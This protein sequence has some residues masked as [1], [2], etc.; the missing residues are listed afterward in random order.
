MA[1][2]KF[3]CIK[4]SNPSNL[5]IRFYHGRNIDCNAQSH[6]LINP[7]D[8]SEKMQ[9]FKPN[10]DIAI[11][12][13]YNP[14]IDNLKKEIL[15][16][17]N[18][19]YSKGT[20]IN[21]KWLK[22]TIQ[23]FHKR[24]EGIEEYKIYFVSFIEKFIEDSKTR[25]NPVSGKKIADNTLKKYTTTLNKIKEFEKAN[26]IRLK[27]IDI[28][29]EFHDKLTSYLKIDLKYSNTFIA[30]VISQI[31][32]FIREAKEKRLEINPDIESKK[33][34]FTT[35]ETIDTY[36]NPSEIDLIN[37]LDLTDNASLDNV[38]DLFIIGLW[39]GLRISDLKR[40]NHFLFTKN[41]IV[42]SETDK[43][44]VTVEIPIHPQVRNI[45]IKRANKMP[46]VISTQKFNDYI[47]EVCK[48]ARITQIILGNIKDPKTNR[49]VRGHYPK[50]KLIS[51]HTARRSFATNHY[52][53]LPDRTIMACTGHKSLQ[54]FHKYLKA[55]QKDH[56]EK[57]ETYW[58]QQDELKNAKPTLKSVNF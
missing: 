38:R 27:L 7:S 14:L 56:I 50:Y 36:L 18:I 35:D 12:N 54:Q 57:I 21:S 20:I 4:K 51:S 13:Q 3:S 53:D 17:F 19:E 24:P 25:I 30:K 44:G 49:K 37:N 29:L 15:K 32:L 9:N 1:N 52:G 43:T 10:T 34:T 58:E 6:I 2:F 45:L 5:N 16:K 40:I 46:N 28:N 33:F 11:K 47:K 8:W 39:T 26:N 42:I 41:T 55:T 22:K 31:K 48:L 23:D